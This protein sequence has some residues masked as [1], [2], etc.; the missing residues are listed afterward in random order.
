MN[1][2]VADV[3]AFR[4]GELNPLAIYDSYGTSWYAE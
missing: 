2:F 1:E 3:N 4:D